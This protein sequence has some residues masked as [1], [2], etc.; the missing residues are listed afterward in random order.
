MVGYVPTI[1]LCGQ[2]HSHRAE[3]AGGPQL[4]TCCAGGGRG[5]PQRA[6]RGA[7][8]LLGR[9][10]LPRLDIVAAQGQGKP[11]LA[12]GLQTAVGAA[13]HPTQVLKRP[14]LR[15]F[16]VLGSQRSTSANPKYPDRKGC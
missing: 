4:R 16:R 10:D 6:Q 13:Q 1:W 7:Q 9:A 3:G 15:G 2:R 8:L 5:G 14:L 11:Q 12:Q